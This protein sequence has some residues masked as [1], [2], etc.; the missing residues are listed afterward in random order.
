MR[1][2]ACVHVFMCVCGVHEIASVYVRS[3]ER[4]AYQKTFAVDRLMRRS[5]HTSELA[6]MWSADLH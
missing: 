4:D 2:C 6:A 3:S 5:G 1:V